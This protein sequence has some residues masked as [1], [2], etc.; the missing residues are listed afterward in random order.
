MEWE[1]NRFTTTFKNAGEGWIEL[2]YDRIDEKLDEF[3]QNGW[4]LVSAVTSNLRGGISDDLIF[5]FKRPLLV[6]Y[7]DEDENAE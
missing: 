3:G 1:Y 7:A 5:F 4:E 6:E 2:D